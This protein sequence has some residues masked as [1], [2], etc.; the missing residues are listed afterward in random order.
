MSPTAAT[1]EPS[2]TFNVVF[3]GAG[4]IHF[5]TLEGSWNHSLR[6]ETLLG[7]RL[8]VLALID[9]DVPRSRSR[10]ATKHAHDDKHVRQAWQDTLCAASPEEAAEQLRKDGKEEVHLVLIGAPPHVRGALA[11]GRDLE[12]RVLKALG[13]AKAIFLEKPVAAADPL[14]T[15][16]EAAE[17]QARLEQW[18]TGGKVVGVG[19][20][21]R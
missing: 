8:R 17:V 21:L 4:E 15:E 20:M 19:Y 2:A 9:P 18:A 5:G 3:L 16:P 7:A 12:V 1:A 13:H 10:V 6:L 14:T 11:P